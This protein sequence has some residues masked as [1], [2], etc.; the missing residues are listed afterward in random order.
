MEIILMDGSF[1]KNRTFHASEPGDPHSQRPR[2]E[3]R[4][5]STRFPSAV[6][7]APLADTLAALERATGHPPKPNGQGWISRCPAH[8]DHTP[9][10]SVSVGHTG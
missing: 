8:D 5:P 4:V 10:L 9:S 1:Y 2:H 6:T 7:S 3:A